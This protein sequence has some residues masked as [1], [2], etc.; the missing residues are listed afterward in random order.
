MKVSSNGKAPRGRPV[1]AV[2]AS[3]GEVLRA[4]RIEQNG[5]GR[6]RTQSCRK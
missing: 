6:N 1:G 3:G 4:V 2:Q 5:R